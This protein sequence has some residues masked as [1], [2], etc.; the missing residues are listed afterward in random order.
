M[1][2]KHNDKLTR[3]FIRLAMLEQGFSLTVA[4]EGDQGSD[5]DKKK[6][7]VERVKQKL[8]ERQDKA[9]NVD[10]GN[11]AVASRVRM[12]KDFPMDTEITEE[13]YDEVMDAVGDKLDEAAKGDSGES[14][15]D[16][17]DVLDSVGDKLDEAAK[18][19]PDKTVPETETSPDEGG[20]ESSQLTLVEKIV[21]MV[22]LLI[23]ANPPRIKKSSEAEIDRAAEVYL[24]VAEKLVAR[25]IKKVDRTD[26]GKFKIEY[27]DG[28]TEYSEKDPRKT[29]QGGK[30]EEPA[31]GGK[32]KKPK[33]DESGGGESEKKPEKKQE[34]S[35][36]KPDWFDEND[37]LDPKDEKKMKGRGFS[38]KPLK[39][40]ANTTFVDVTTGEEV[41]FSDLPKEAQDELTAL[42]EKG[43]LWITPGSSAGGGDAETETTTEPEKAP[44]SDGKG[45]GDS[46]GGK[47]PSKKKDQGGGETKKQPE[48]TKDLS[49]ALPDDK[50]KLEEMAKGFRQNVK[51][52]DFKERIK[53]MSIQELI[54]LLLVKLE[55]EDEGLTAASIRAVTDRVARW[56]AKGQQTKRKDKDLMNDTGGTSKGRP[57][58]PDERPPRYDLRK[59]WNKKKKKPSE[60]DKD[61]DLDKDLRKD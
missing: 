17:G 48:S 14:S 39:I 3:A 35:K 1:S 6:K 59:P 37:P 10:K 53:G 27:D 52:P 25:E 16:Y 49:E 29:D 42:A 18:G 23:K 28:T 21:D 46:G 38:K 60:M 50:Q 45:E 5:D 11:L 13:N 30:K 44:E 57:A 9:N 15:D 22:T 31:D 36:K 61:T 2:K 55:D 54:Q 12:A 7:V 40:D 24:R 51:S 58:E 43:D 33:P 41:K 19:K 8:K 32:K 34:P 56:A 20:S 26:S 47:A 4:D